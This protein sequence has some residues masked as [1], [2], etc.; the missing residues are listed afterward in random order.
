MNVLGHAFVAERIRP[1]DDAH[2]FGAVLPDLASMAGVRID[3]ADAGG[4]ALAAGVRCH[5]AADTAFHS[6]PAFVAG[7]AAMRR[8]LLAAGLATGPA[9]AVAHVGYELLLDATLLGGDAE[10]AYRRAFAALA[11]AE[12]T[13]AALR[14]AGHEQW[15]RAV[16]GFA[17]RSR[18]RGGDGDPA[19]IA[20]RL[21]AILRHR[22]RLA[23]APDDAPVVAAVLGR[24]ADDVRRAAPA[25]LALVTARAT[26][27]SH[28]AG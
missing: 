22:P 15:R 19:A 25:V 3:R 20:E 2:T 24:H 18:G 12:P 14:P 11:T 7:A 26:F 13:F 1:G 17:A 4:A 5:H 23:L 16:S 27:A 9:R 28:D 8:E 6:A 21:V 10:H